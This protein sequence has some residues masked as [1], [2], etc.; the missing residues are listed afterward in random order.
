[1]RI[2]LDTSALIS[3]Y[4]FKTENMNRFKASLVKHQVVLCSY[5]IDETKAV[6]AQKFPDKRKALVVL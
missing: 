4:I 2:M 6:V 1:M 5:V 3:L